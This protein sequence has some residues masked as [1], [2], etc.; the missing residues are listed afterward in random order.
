[1]AEDEEE[2]GSAEVE[3]DDVGAVSGMTGPEFFSASLGVSG[4]GSFSSSM[5]RH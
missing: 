4:P 1:M 3:V 5:V 2:E